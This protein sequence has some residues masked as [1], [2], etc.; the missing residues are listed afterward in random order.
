[1]KK[2]ITLLL[3]L[4]MTLSICACGSSSNVLIS[5]ALNDGTTKEF[6]GTG[7]LVATYQE[8][9]IVN[10]EQYIHAEATVE[11]NIVEIEAT[12]TYIYGL[13]KDVV[14]VE[15]EDDI[16][17]YFDA[18]YDKPMEMVKSVSVGDYVKAKGTLISIDTAYVALSAYE[19]EHVEF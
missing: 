14:K 19:M 12:K 18:A 4:V 3:A 6:N 1:M 7:D 10:E 17:L 9:E 13:Y 16:C 8:N 5:V 15:L 11:G 2:A